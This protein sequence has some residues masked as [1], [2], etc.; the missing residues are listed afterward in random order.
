M[1]NFPRFIIPE[2]YSQVSTGEERKGPSAN[3]IRR[4]LYWMDWP[5][6]RL[7]WWLAYSTNWDGLY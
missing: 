2:F 3:L 7:D 4:I 5:A 1:L 6:C